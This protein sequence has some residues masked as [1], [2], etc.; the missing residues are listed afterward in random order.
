LPAKALSRVATL[1]ALL[2]LPAATQAAGGG[3]VTLRCARADVVNPAWNGPITFTFAAGERGPLKV[4]GPFGAFTV[5]AS[6]SPMQLAGDAGEA[7]DGNA[8]A[9]VKLP[10]LS[11]LETCI[12]A[13]QS[14]S[15]D[16]SSDAFPNARD[17]CLRKL[18]PAPA[19]VAAVAQIRIGI[20]GPDDS[21]EDAFVLFK[22]RYD[23]PSHAPGGTMAV[24]AFPAQCTL[25]K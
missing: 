3:A 13:E 22:L 4:E 23:A 16:T 25:Q 5:P 18:P 24:E 17:A 1:L 15:G 12:S 10:A 6:R 14:A 9:S 2:S 7:I 20:G 21:G 11:D 8:K 19:P